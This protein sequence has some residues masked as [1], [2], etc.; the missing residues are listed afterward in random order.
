MFS[1]QCCT[2]VFLKEA[3]YMTYCGIDLCLH[4][5]LVQGHDFPLTLCHI[6]VWFSNT[7]LSVMFWFTS[8]LIC[9]DH[10]LNSF[11]EEYLEI[12]M[13]KNEIPTKPQQLSGRPLLRSISYFDENGTIPTTICSASTSCF[14]QFHCSLANK[15]YDL[16]QSRIP[17][18]FN[19]DQT[20]AQ[21]IFRYI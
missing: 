3:P 11:K 20:R 14:K 17:V 7:F 4:F 9:L 15:Q 6:C 2:S 13:V 1:I 18:T 10:V 8:E 12:L 21:S 5:N 16:R 19:V